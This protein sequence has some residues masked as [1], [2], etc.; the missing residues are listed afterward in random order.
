MASVPQSS[1]SLVTHIH[2]LGNAQQVITVTSSSWGSSTATVQAFEN[3]GA[4]WRTVVGPTPAFVGVNGFA[5]NKQEGDG[6]TPAGVYGFQFM[7]GTAPS[8]GVRYAYRQAGPPDVWV[9]DPAS[10][11]Y[12][13]WQEAPADGRWSHAEQLDQPGPYH[14]AAVIAY[15]TARVPGKG[16]A[17]FL[18]VSMG[19]G[20]AGCVAVAE[21]ALLEIL[22]WLDPGRQPV[23]AMGPQSYVASP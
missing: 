19:H 7:F 5:S 2:G 15:N 14:E 16:S 21:P 12:N 18:H 23:I 6:R 10:S 11:L 4:G 17:I 3:D 1:S 20:T 22:R 13:T 8:P 9:D